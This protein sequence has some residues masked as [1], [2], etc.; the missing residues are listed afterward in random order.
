MDPLRIKW[1]LKILCFSDDKRQ[2]KD[3]E[4][5]QTKTQ[6]ELNRITL[7]HSVFRAPYFSLP[8]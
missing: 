1:N 6:R 2:K 8:L 3:Q 5:K 4:E 7:K